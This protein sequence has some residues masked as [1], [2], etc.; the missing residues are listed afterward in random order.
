MSSR[1]LG[2]NAYFNSLDVN[3]LEVNRLRVLSLTAEKESAEKES[4]DN[5]SISY[6]FSCVFNNGSFQRNQTGGFLTMNKSD[7]QSIIQ[8]SDRPFRDSTNITFEDFVSLFIT[9]GVD[10]FKEDPPNGVLTHSEDQ[11]TYII[12]LSSTNNEKTTATFNLELLPNE[13]HNLSNVS[14]RMNFFVDNSA[15]VPPNN[16]STGITILQQSGNINISEGTHN[17]TN[18]LIPGGISGITI[19]GGAKVT[20][21]NNVPFTDNAHVTLNNGTLINNNKTPYVTINGTN[22]ILNNK[23]T[24]S[25]VTNNSNSTKIYNSYII[26]K[27]VVQ[28]V[29][30]ISL[31][32][33]STLTNVLFNNTSEVSVNQLIFIPDEDN[34]KT[35]IKNDIKFTGLINGTVTIYDDII[36]N[37]YLLDNRDNYVN[38]YMTIIERNGKISGTGY[39]TAGITIQSRNINISE[40]THNI[41]NNLIPGGISGITINGGAKVTIENNVPFTDNAHVTLNNGTLIN[42]NKTPYVTINGT[43]AILNNKGTISSVTNNSNSTKIYNSYIIEKLVV[44]NVTRISLTENSTLTNVLFNNTSEVSVNQ[45]I[46]IPDEDNNKTE[47]KNDIKFTGLINGTVTIYDDIINN[48]YLLDNRDNYVNTYMTIIE[49]NGKISGTGYPSADTYLDVYSVT[50]QSV[51]QHVHTINTNITMLNTDDLTVNEKQL[52][53]DIIQYTESYIKKIE[54]LKGY[55]N[56]TRLTKYT[57]HELGNLPSFKDIITLTSSLKSTLISLGEISNS[58][59]L[60]YTFNTLIDLPTIAAIVNGSRLI[61]EHLIN[62]TI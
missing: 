51:E 32:E 43:N 15:G 23:G 30:R 17:I 26:E 57:I 58:N 18:N 53:D 46:F 44:Q 27:L 52:L 24:I 14:G 35:E 41:T 2:K 59:E 47:I 37:A 39:P 34:N 21:E 20:I 29:T 38:T 45:L 3:R 31:T 6:L 55:M 54:S 28:N 13:T 19:N 11:T 4:P 10:S 33:N 61:N 12:R 8:F 9:S 36:N 62:F 60:L 7:T 22:A 49:R 42:N 50:D 5:S 48:A 56:T 16:S 40:G 25:S 1:S